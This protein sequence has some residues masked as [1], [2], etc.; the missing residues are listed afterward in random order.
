MET[1]VDDSHAIY[2]R[3]H[4]IRTKI[5]QIVDEREEV[6]ESTVD[7]YRENVIMAKSENVI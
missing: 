3:V 2:R 7:K 5:K 1:R 4:F 6:Q